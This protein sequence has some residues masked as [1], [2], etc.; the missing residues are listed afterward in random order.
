MILALVVSGLGHIYLGFVKRGIIILIIGVVIWIFVSWLFP[1][2]FSWLIGVAYW[3]WQM[4]DA[5]NH[6]K[7]LKPQ[8]PQTGK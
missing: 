2:P 8:E 7:R 5:Y 6:Y 3:I 4:W 1:I